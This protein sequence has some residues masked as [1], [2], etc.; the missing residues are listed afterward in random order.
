MKVRLVYFNVSSVTEETT[1]VPYAPQAAWSFCSDILYSA[2][3]IFIL[4]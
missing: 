3:V 2:R 4:I 1:S